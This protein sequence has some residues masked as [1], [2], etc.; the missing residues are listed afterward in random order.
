MLKL[1]FEHGTSFE[2][3]HLNNMTYLIFM[4]NLKLI[5]LKKKLKTKL[6]HQ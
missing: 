1:E 4:H 6:K 3:K 2:K 5:L